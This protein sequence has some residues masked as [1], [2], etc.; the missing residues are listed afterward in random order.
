MSARA[1]NASICVPVDFLREA[2]TTKEVETYLLA[3]ASYPGQLEIHRD[4][5]FEQHLY[6]LLHAQQRSSNTPQ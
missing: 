2:A 4:L 1:S 6:N 5:T 3:V